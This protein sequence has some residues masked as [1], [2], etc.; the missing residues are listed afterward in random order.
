M[1]EKSKPKPISLRQLPVLKSL[2]PKAE[3][4]HCTTELFTDEH[5]YLYRRFL[6]FLF[7]VG[8]RKNSDVVVEHVDRIVIVQRA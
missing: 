2:C 3:K 7:V 6:Y 1:S 8:V 4:T 5:L